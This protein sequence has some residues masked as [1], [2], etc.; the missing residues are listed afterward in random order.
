MEFE[1]TL[2]K[3]D[4]LSCA[5]EI[6][7]DKKLFL[8]FFKSCFPFFFMVFAIVALFVFL[9]LAYFINSYYFNLTYTYIIGFTIF[10]LLAIFLFIYK[11]K[12]YLCRFLYQ[13]HKVHYD[14][15]LSF[16]VAFDKM[17]V[18][19]YSNNNVQSFHI[20]QIKSVVMTQ[21]AYLFTFNDFDN[22]YWLL[23]PKNSIKEEEKNIFS[24]L[25][26]D[27]SNTKSKFK[28]KGLK[29]K[30]ILNSFVLFLLLYLCF[31]SPSFYPS[32]TIGIKISPL[33]IISHV[34]PN[35]LADKAGIGAGYIIYE[36]NGENVLYKS[37]WQIVKKIKENKNLNFKIIDANKFE[38]KDYSITK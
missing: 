4:F 37:S 35:S 16:K 38:I 8:T 31:S 13:N 21:N 26:E 27:L 29:I 34:E 33:S 15:S 1:Y 12:N 20:S 6:Q 17:N 18:N 10:T 36:I 30:Y 2:N 5:E 19:I 32:Q 14:K 11:S 28:Y 3:D 23:L 7:K 25:L 24:M 9:V 22:F